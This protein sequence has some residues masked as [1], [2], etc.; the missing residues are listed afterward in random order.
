MVMVMEKLLYEKI[1]K[2]DR[3]LQQDDGRQDK[4][5]QNS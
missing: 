3:S 1:L 5:L 2:K 4:D